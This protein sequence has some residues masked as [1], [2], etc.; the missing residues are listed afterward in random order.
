ML[1]LALSAVQ[2]VQKFSWQTHKTI[3]WLMYARIWLLFHSRL[4]YLPHSNTKM[5]IENSGSWTLSYDNLSDFKVNLTFC[6][7]IVNFKGKL[8]VARRA[9]VQSFCFTCSF[10]NE[11]VIL[12]N[13]SWRYFGV[14][15][16]CMNYFSP[17]VEGGDKIYPKIRKKI[18]RKA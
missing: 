11:L 3:L 17:V 6:N 8:Y 5:H 15:I 4:E 7:L 12:L 9:A 14:V 13:C 2:V 18:S 1:Y 16:L 10:K